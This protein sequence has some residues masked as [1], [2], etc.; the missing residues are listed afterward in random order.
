MFFL[1]LLCLGASSLPGT[2]VQKLSRSRTIL[3]ILL[4][5][6]SLSAANTT[7]S[8]VD[9]V[10]EK[11]TCADLCGQVARVDRVEETCFLCTV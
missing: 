3:S 5:S 9:V 11:V 1:F 4:N 7:L 8:S 6:P 2:L 10:V